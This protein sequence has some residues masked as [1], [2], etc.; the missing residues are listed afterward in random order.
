MGPNAR[1]TVMRAGLELYDGRVRDNRGSLLRKRGK[2]GVLI[3]VQNLP[4]PMDRRVWLECGALTDAG[5]QVSVICIAGPDDPPYELLDGVHIYKYKPAPQADGT[6]GFVWEFAYSWSRAAALSVRVWRRHGFDVLQACN[7]P[8]TYWLLGFLYRLVGKRFVYDQHDLNPEVFLSRFGDPRG[9]VQRAQYRMLLTLEA[10]TYRFAHHVI[11]TNESYREVAMTRGR[12]K[13]GDVT[14]V[15][16]GPDTSVM[17]PVAE[18]PTDASPLRNGR[19]Y[20]ACYLGIMGPQDGVDVLLQAVDYYVN[21]LG[22]DD[23]QF[24]LLGFGDCLEMLR[25]MSTALGLD[26]YVTFTGRANKATI[27]QYLSAADVGVSPDPLNPLND[28]STMN[29]TMEYMAYAVPVVAF[30]LK[31][32][33]V[34]AQQAAVYVQPGDIAG[35]ASALGDLLDDEDRRAQMAVQARLRA[36]AELDWRPQAIAYVGVYDRLLGFGGDRRGDAGAW[37]GVERRGD[38]VAPRDHDGKRLVDL[39][40]SEELQRFVRRRQLGSPAP[41]D[42]EPDDQEPGAA[43]A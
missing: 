41:D 25:E 26:D 43:Q 29:K 39:R 34:S 2:P 18:S 7:P 24:A 11:S 16:S 20:L 8:D 27:A 10:L 23:C 31:E 38:D 3:V 37:P 9:L 14:V 42:Q 36:A 13:P 22:R 33:R 35:F 12:R 5:Y 28:V 21:V 40:D 1:E 32:T 6:L 19:S 15:R 17:R 4:V 30:D